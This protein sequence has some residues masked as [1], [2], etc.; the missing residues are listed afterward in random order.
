MHNARTFQASIDGH[1]ATV[2]DLA[3]LA[4]AGF[5]HFTAMQV[6]NGRVRGLDLHLARLQAASVSLFGRALPDSRVREYIRAA[7]TGPADLSLTVT[8]FSHAGEFTRAGAADDPAALVRTSPASNG[9]SSPLRLALVEHER[10]LPG[11]KQVGEA[12]KT[13]F[14]RQAVRDGFDDAAFVDRSGRISE[15]TIWN[16]AFWDGEA[17]IWPEADALPGVTMQIIC[18]QLKALGIMQRSEPIT[19]T[20]AAQMSGAA[21]MN[22]W[23][24]GLMVAAIG[25]AE[26]PESNVFIDHLHRAYEQEPAETV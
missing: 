5:A 11:I 14:L 13:H 25:T 23:T 19:A 21:V 24:P 9:P 26:L 8:M 22:S 4:F 6:R 12:A 16:I 15:A 2:D 20:K 1:T 10:W 3:P 18:R 17:V 7:I